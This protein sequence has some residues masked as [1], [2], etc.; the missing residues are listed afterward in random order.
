MPPTESADQPAIGTDPDKRRATPLWLRIVGTAGWTFITAGVLIVLFVVYQLWGTSIQEASFQHDLRGQFSAQLSST[1]TG[2]VSTTTTPDTTVSAT[3]V[4]GTVP[5][6]TSTVPVVPAPPDVPRLDGQPVARIEI[7]KIGVD[8]IVVAGT[9][10]E[11][12]KKGPGLYVGTPLP[13]HLGNTSIAGHRTTFGAPFYRVNELAPGDT[14]RITTVQGVFVYKVTTQLIVEPTNV[15]VI[16][17]TTDA[18]LTLTSCNPRYSAK[19]RIVIK[20]RLD[21]A[22]SPPITVPIGP[23]P[24]TTPPTTQPGSGGSTTTVSDTTTIV[25]ATT[26]ADPSTVGP[27]GQ[28]QADAFT[29]GWFSDAAA[30]PQ[31]L[32]WALGLAVIVMAT[33]RLGRQVR[34]R[35][36]API[37][38]L[39]PFVVVLYF[40]YENLARLLPPNI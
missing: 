17:P 7:P 38:A 36:L 37:A 33:W 34:H 13:G 10:V 8:K 5:A 25:D 35:W 16:A 22:V 18:Q 30:W 40:F 14:I 21:D 24:T 6:S 11:D 28:L 12:L 9:S 3:T 2:S 1:T 23:P 19:Q 26:I 20:A 31:V 39:V 29:E 27:G 15:G 32:A 4:P